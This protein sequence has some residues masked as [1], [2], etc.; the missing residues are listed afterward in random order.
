M[1]RIV[2]DQAAITC[3]EF[4]CWTFDSVSSGGG[5]C[6]MIQRIDVVFGGIDGGLNRG[7][8]CTLWRY[9]PQIDVV[10]D[11][12]SVATLVEHHA[13]LRSMGIR[14]VCLD[15]DGDFARVEAHE[16][17]GRI[18]ADQLNEASDE[19]LIELRAVVAFQDGENTVG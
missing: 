5:E 8:T 18:D 13:D 9:F 16:V 10:G 12:P 14:R 1:S 17:T 3:P 4:S 19:M 11:G 2:S 15:D 6:D 7:R